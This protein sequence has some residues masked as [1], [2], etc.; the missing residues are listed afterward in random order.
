MYCKRKGGVWCRE[1]TK[2]QCVWLILLTYGQSWS[3]AVTSPGGGGG[4]E[5]ERGSRGSSRRT[6]FRADFRRGGGST[7][8]STLLSNSTSM[9]SRPLKSTQSPGEVT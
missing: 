2:Y 6:A 8:P 9:G 5:G 1:L 7:G 4:E 3:V